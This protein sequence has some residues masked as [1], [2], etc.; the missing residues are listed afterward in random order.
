MFVGAGL[1]VFPLMK[2][3]T[4]DG[5]RVFRGKF[6]PAAYHQQGPGNAHLAVSGS[7]HPAE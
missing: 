2:L 1:F 5:Y 6:E 7:P 3:Y 4:V